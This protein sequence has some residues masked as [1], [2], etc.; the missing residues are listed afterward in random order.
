MIIRHT[1]KLTI[2]SSTTVNT[3]FAY[4]YVRALIVNI[5]LFII[6]RYVRKATEKNN[7]TRPFLLPGNLFTR[8]TLLKGSKIKTTFLI[9]KVKNII[10]ILF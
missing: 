1:L 10:F 5:I 6:I 9:K 3:K 7:I 4:T 8:K 2:V